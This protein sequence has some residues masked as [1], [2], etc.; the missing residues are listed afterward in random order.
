MR[1]WWGPS[2]LRR[3]V[4]TMLAALLL[5]WVALSLK[6]YW[7]FRQ[8]VRSRESLGRVTQSILDS[9]QGFDPPQA[10]AA[11][12]AADRVYNDLRRHAE[13][14]AGGALLFRLSGL[15]GALVYLSPSAHGLPD[16]AAQGGPDRVSFQG[17][18]HWPVVRQNAHWRLAVWVPVLEN[19]AAL[20]RIGQEVL[21]YVL[22]ALPL[23]LLPLGLAV[24]LGLRPLHS[25]SLRRPDDLSP[26]C[27]PTGYAEL[28]P[29]V[30]AFNA[31]LDR[32]RRQ[33]DAEQAFV[34]DAAHELKTP[35][36]VVAAQAHVLV[37][38]QDDVQRTVALRALE[39]GVQRASHQVNQLLTLAALEHA[40]TTLPC[41]TDLVA[42]A[43]EV[44]IELEPLTHARHQELVL[45][46]P[47]RLCHPVDVQA[48]RSVLVNL[49]RNAIQHGAAGGTVTIG[50]DPSA[51]TICLAVSDDGPG[52][53]QAERERVFDRFH[54]G[55]A[56]PSSA[57]SGL[58][59]AI[60]RR[61]AQRLQASVVIEDGPD[62]H[63]ITVLL[64]FGAA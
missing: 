9:L 13:P 48:L 41:Q 17:R 24:W 15:D 46:S 21:G 33:R 38:A 40:H 25:L 43:R 27:E 58:G 11:L 6:D 44:L 55:L 50:L 26:L 20:A 4:L 22:L 5:V 32:A 16:L 23:V 49:V 3:I 51:G 61:A 14:E 19:G 1:R 36:A 52:I 62:G 35:L 42:L 64:R 37:V 30:D 45:Q 63:G 12:Q 7:A 54:R 57:G 34:Q 39:Q 28:A 31:L 53:P 18:D 10:Q 59:L 56:A 8:D 60:V 2:L 47:D 29:L